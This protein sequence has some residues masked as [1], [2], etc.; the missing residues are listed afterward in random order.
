MG[1]SDGHAFLYQ[2]EVG[3][4]SRGGMSAAL[5]Q[6]GVGAAS[7]ASF[8]GELLQYSAWEAIER[9][10]NLFCVYPSLGKDVDVFVSGEPVLLQMG[11]MSADAT[12]AYRASE[13]KAWLAIVLRN[14]NS[15][16]EAAAQRQWFG[17]A[18]N[19]NAEQVRQRI[20]RTFNFV[21]REFAQGFYFIIPAENAK[22]SSCNVGAVAYVWRAS[23][24]TTTGYMETTGPRCN[25]NDNPRTKNC[26]LDQYGKYYIYL[27][28][29]FL[30]Q[31]E[32]YQ[33]G[34]LIHEAAHH[35]GPNDVTYNK[36]RAQ[37]ESQYNQLMN[38]A[39]YQ[40]CAQA[41]NEGGC[42]D[43][44]GNCVHYT[45][46]CGQAR[47]KD[48][49][50]KSCGLCGSGGGGGSGSQGCADTYGSCKWYKDNNYCGTANVQA[51]CKR[52]CGAC[53]QALRDQ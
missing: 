24:R 47:I 19:M 3:Q 46:Y 5:L 16:Q 27:C 44:D 18:G 12:V 53:R 7:N 48:L 49:C 17:G 32:S 33:V 25:S 40:Y 43:K 31:A 42:S 21:N 26:A 35:A 30:S 9:I 15:N 20:L 51:Q 36:D 29:D 41:V 45:S 22:Q 39:N 50:Q 10:A 28:N 14:V 2:R 11:T 6:R 37:R 1:D 8:G 13:A 52:T 38:A 23:A 34:V 4:I